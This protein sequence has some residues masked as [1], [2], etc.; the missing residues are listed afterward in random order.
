MRPVRSDPRLG[1][2]L[3]RFEAVCERVEPGGFRV[4][5]TVL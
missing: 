4:V 2:V 3:E 5:A 1:D